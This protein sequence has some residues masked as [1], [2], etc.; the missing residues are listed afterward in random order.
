MGSLRENVVFD[1]N[2][3]LADSVHIPVLTSLTN[4]VYVT[5]AGV[6][7]DRIVKNRKASNSIINAYKLLEDVFSD[8]QVTDEN[9]LD[10][11]GDRILTL[12]ELPLYEATLKYDGTDPDITLYGLGDTVI[13]NV[14]EECLNYTQYRVKKRTVDI[15]QTQTMTVQLDLLII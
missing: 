14:P 12:Q 10:A 3:I 8:Q 9:L 4:S 15:D 13:I 2:N 6:N 11:D 7:N 5:G 1:D